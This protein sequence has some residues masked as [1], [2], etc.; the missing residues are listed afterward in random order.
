M[1]KN[2]IANGSLTNYIC[3]IKMIKT[4]FMINVKS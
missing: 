2:A 4:K 1:Y 3:N